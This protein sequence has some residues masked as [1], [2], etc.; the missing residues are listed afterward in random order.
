[1]IMSGPVLPLL[2]NFFLQSPFTNSEIQIRLSKIDTTAVLGNT[3]LT[4]L[5]TFLK[6]FFDNNPD[7][8]HIADKVDNIDSVDN[9]GNVGLVDFVDNVD[10]FDMSPHYL[11][12]LLR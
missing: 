11:V 5:T 10:N 12:I 7:N 1:M 6:I 8:V 2:Y 4:I 9:N 3:T